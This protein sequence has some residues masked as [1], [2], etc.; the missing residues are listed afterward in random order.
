MLLNCR[1]VDSQSW[2]VS[3]SDDATVG[4]LKKAIED[5]RCVPSELLT[6]VF[7]GAELK[8][9]SD[10]LRSKGLKNESALVVV[11]R[12]QGKKS[13]ARA[14][15]PVG[16][17]AGPSQPTAGPDAH[18][19]TL[20]PVGAS[21]RAETVQNLMALGLGG[22]SEKMVVAA[23]ESAMWVPDRA[24]QYLSTG[25]VPA[26]HKQTPLGE[27]VAALGPRFQSTLEFL[28]ANA[29]RVPAFLTLLD[30][31]QPELGRLIR[32]HRQDFDAMV[33]RGGVDDSAAAAAP[34]GPPVLAPAHD[35]SVRRIAE[36]GVPLSIA[37]D[38]YMAAGCNELV[39]MNRILDGSCF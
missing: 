27:T 13:A 19:R 21:E 20:E 11:V 38:V 39:A 10:T 35:E 5:T 16:E 24:F 30:R 32:A 15:A 36:M 26:A 22:W 7:H 33:R 29:D 4:D 6:L 34:T 31:Q 25:S 1:T 3:V 8:M 14:S 18:N 17:P 28:K 37:R 2:Q 12:K 9:G 23:L